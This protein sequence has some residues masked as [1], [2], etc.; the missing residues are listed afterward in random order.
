MSDEPADARPVDA[1]RKSRRLREPWWK[2]APPDVLLKGAGTL[3]YAAVGGFVFWHFKLPLAFMIGAMLFTAVA[4][5]LGVRLQNPGKLRFMMIS[6]LGVMLGSGFTPEAVS[7]FVDWIPSLT[8]LIFFMAFVAGTIAFVL[9]RYVGWDPVTSYFS[10]MPGGFSVMVILTEAFGGDERR[11]SLVHV[12]RIML[13]VM[14]IPFWFRFFEGYHPGSAGPT[15]SL[16]AISYS[17]LAILVACAFIG[18][19]VGR[20]LRLPSAALLGPTLV[21]GVVHYLGITHAKPPSEIINLA[22]V[23]IGASVGCRFVGISILSVLGTVGIGMLSALFILTCATTAAI[24][25]SEL[26]GLPFDALLLA[27][28][29][30]GLAEMTLISLALGI[31]VAFVS[32]HHMLR[33]AFMMFT[34]PMAFR[35]MRRYH[36]FQKIRR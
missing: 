12:V 22:Q 17:D 11:V 30:G 21:S 19:P 9:H 3:I 25:L 29:P 14:T 5:F 28:A 23:V 6:V 7:H 34:G 2:P 10:G 16:A 4:A 18:F 27:F 8:T 15:G 36:V 31:D 32:T 1:E 33:I 13:T 26:T 35:L 24:V 20:L